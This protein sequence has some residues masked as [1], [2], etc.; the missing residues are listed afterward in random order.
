MNAQT[1]QGIITAVDGEPYL[2]GTER[3]RS[4]GSGIEWAEPI[5]D[6]GDGEECKCYNLH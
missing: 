5:D 3:Y 1:A 6:P 4:R 2:T